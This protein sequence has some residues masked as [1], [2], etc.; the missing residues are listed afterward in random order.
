MSQ[1]PATSSR[2]VDP[3]LTPSFVAVLV[4]RVQWLVVL[5]WFYAGALAVLGAAAVWVRAVRPWDA[6][7]ATPAALLTVAGLMALHSALMWWVLGRCE[8][9][10]PAQVGR[11]VRVVTNVQMAL[12]LA[13]LGFLV[14]FTDVWFLA[15]ILV[16]HVAVGA[17]LLPS[18]DSYVQAGLAGAWVC[19]AFWTG[20]WQGSPHAGAVAHNALVL[21]A[22]AFWWALLL[23]SV[24]FTRS[25]LS[26]LRN[27]NRRLTRANEELAELDRTKSR[28]LRLSSHQLRGNVAAIHSML[29]AMET[30]SPLADRQAA[31]ARRIRDRASELVEQMDEM[32][33][34]STVRENGVEIRN[35][36]SVDLASVLAEAVDPLKAQ[37]RDKGLALTVH[38]EDGPLYV[39]AWS[40]AL[41]VVVQNLLSN[42]LKYTLSGG[43]V[44]VTLRRLP[45]DRAELVVADTGIG[46]APV[47]QE[48]VFHEFHRAPQARQLA[49]GTGL[50]LPIVQTVVQRLGGRVSLS[51]THGEGT[52]VTVLLPL[53]QVQGAPGETAAGDTDDSHPPTDRNASL[54]SESCERR[55]PQA[56][57]ERTQDASADTSKVEV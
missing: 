51:S 23:L 17:S 46:I 57:K 15:A 43:R 36:S 24:W 18:R 4:A 42:A 21:L 50:G 47:Q 27:I 3:V 52:T 9:H 31:L 12:D 6:A 13:M 39:Q 49:G 53:A 10:D 5:R 34:L 45:G 41:A 44:D 16:F 7:Q 26:R 2:P 28:F 30:V 8:R 1:A 37:A 14:A 19:G 55:P 20:Q 40:D 35:R 25:I 32:L 48:Q 38:T 33:L 54:N 11:F 22:G 29:G 56:G